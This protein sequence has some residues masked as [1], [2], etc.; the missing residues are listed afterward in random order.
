MLKFEFGATVEQT[1]NHFS[2]IVLLKPGL[3]AAPPVFI[4]PGLGAAAQQV[5]NLAKQIETSN[6]VYGLQINDLNGSLIGNVAP[7]LDNIIKLQSRGPYLLAGYSFGGLVMLEIAR[8]LTDRG[9]KIALLAL[10][11]TYPA[12]RHWPL[13]P[14]MRWLASQARR[15]LSTMLKL[16]MRQALRYAVDQLR[17]E[18]PAKLLSSEP[19]SCS[20]RDMYDGY[21]PQYYAGSITFLRAEEVASN[22]PEDPVSIWGHLALNLEIHNV[23]GSHLGMILSAQQAQGVARQLTVC[24]RSAQNMG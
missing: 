24:L 6:P 11:D 5:S 17:S 19:S 8:R 13:R 3:D 16:P 15:R 1:A 18:V 23:P 14:R 7:L 22:F 9:D 12:R 20:S 21:R 2:P 4:A 10:L